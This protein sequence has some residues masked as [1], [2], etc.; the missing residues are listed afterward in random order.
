MEEIAGSYLGFQ[1]GFLKKQSKIL[2]GSINIY[3]IY[4][5]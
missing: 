1:N 2:S 3:Q 5:T 4:N